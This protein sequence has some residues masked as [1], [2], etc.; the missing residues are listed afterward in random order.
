MIIPGSVEQ[1]E[2]LIVAGTK[3]QGT[4]TWPVVGAG[5][6][7]GAFAEAGENAGGEED[8]SSTSSIPGPNTAELA[9]VMLRAS[10]GA[11]ARAGAGV[12]WTFVSL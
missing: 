7:A 4:G 8:V 5:A 10:F 2:A 3:L 6:E 12:H 1:E 9:E 11:K